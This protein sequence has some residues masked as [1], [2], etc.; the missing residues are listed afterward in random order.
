MSIFE[1]WM[2]AGSF[3]NSAAVVVAVAPDGVVVASAFGLESLLQAGA[4][5]STTSTAMAAAAEVRG[6]PCGT[7]GTLH[8]RR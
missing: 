7:G 2:A 3:E 8:D 4:S 1:D 6:P 5:V